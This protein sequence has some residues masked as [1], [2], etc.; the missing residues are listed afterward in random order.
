MFIDAVVSIWWCT[1]VVIGSGDGDIKVVVIAVGEMIDWWAGDMCVMCGVFGVFGGRGEGC[2]LP[3][4]DCGV[5]MDWW[6]GVDGE[7]RIS[8]R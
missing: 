6:R 5:V 4:H 7:G 2:K 8:P 3:W 1:G